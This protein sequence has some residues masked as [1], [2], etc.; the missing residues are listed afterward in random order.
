M[1]NF[2][3]EKEVPRNDLDEESRMCFLPGGHKNKG[4]KRERLKIVWY[5]II[6]WMGH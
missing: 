4:K 1:V 3:E 2:R 5:I 6:L